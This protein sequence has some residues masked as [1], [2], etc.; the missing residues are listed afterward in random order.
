MN[1]G[2]DDERK[3]EHVHNVQYYVQYL[4][5]FKVVKFNQSSRL[6]KM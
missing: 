1:N 2:L 6:V 5:V 4:N 3:A